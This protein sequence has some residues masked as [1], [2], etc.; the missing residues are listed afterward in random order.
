MQGAR[1]RGPGIT[2]EERRRLAECCAFFKAAKHRA[3]EPGKI[4][5]SDLEEAAADIDAA[6]E[7]CENRDRS[8]QAHAPAGESA[9]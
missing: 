1:R 8:G 3:A 5:A 2:P 4:R 6:I 9:P 7:E